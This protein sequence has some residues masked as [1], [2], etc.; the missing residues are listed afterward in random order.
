MDA[1]PQQRLPKH[2][3][4]L[5]KAKVNTTP[6]EGYLNAQEEVDCFQVGSL[7]LQQTH[8]EQTLK[9]HLAMTLGVASNQLCLGTS[10][11]SLRNILL[12]VVCAHKRNHCLTFA[13]QRPQ[14]KQLLDWHQIEQTTLSLQYLVDLPISAIQEQVQLDTQLLILDHP[15]AITGALLQRFDVADAVTAFDGWVLVDES[16]IGAVAEESMKSMVATCDNALILQRT[17]GGLAVLIAHPELVEILEQCR[18]ALPLIQ[19]QDAAEQ[20]ALT[21]EERETSLILST[22]K[23]ERVELQKALEALPFVE[24]VYPSSTNSLLLSVQKA[25]EVVQFLRESER[26][27]VYRVPVLEDLPQGIRLTLGTPL[28]NL[29]LRSAFEQLPTKMNPKRA[30]WSDVSKGLRRASSFLGFFKKFLGV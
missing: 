18:P 22:L 17:V 3:R 20:L 1:S 5:L 13:P 25:D 2:L 23:K 14:V 6:L 4:N 19:L 7:A 27:L 24:K 21:K 12:Q 8:Q 30:F 26:I 16:S 15:N 11:E 28:D 9:A 10:P 29:R